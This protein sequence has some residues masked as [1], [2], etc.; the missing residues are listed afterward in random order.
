M[1][2]RKEKTR[3]KGIVPISRHINPVQQLVAQDL[4]FVWAAKWGCKRW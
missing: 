1:L 4:L 2:L 3:E